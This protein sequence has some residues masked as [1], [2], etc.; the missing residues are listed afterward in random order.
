MPAPATPR[1]PFV[2]DPADVLIV[3]GSGFN[4]RDTMHWTLR[5]RAAAKTIIIQINIDM[6][7]LTTHSVPGHVVAGSCRAFLD[8]MQDRAADD[9]RLRLRRKGATAGDRLAKVEKPDR[10]Y[11]TSRIASGRRQTDPS[12]QLRFRRYAKFS[13][14]MAHCAGRFRRAPCLCR[15]LLDR[16]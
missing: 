4:E 12:R 8:L 11:T 2:G 14:A 7:E 15:P 1:P 16:L 6:D 3:L 10:G 5:G 9:A 13:R